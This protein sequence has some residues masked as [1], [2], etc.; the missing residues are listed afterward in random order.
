MTEGYRA[1]AMASIPQPV[2]PKKV[3]LA[4]TAIQSFPER[5]LVLK[6]QRLK[7]LIVL[8]LRLRLRLRLSRAWS[9]GP[10]AGPGLD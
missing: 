6:V 10:V 1:W 7:G 5:P 9:M 2:H 3:P 8:I 4:L